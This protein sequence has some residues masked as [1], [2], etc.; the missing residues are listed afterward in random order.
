[1]SMNFVDRD[2]VGDHRPLLCGSMTGI[3]MEFTAY[4]DRDME[5]GTR[6]IRLRIERS[7]IESYKGSFT[8]S[9]SL[10]VRFV[11]SPP[12][13]QSDALLRVDMAPSFVYYDP[14]VVTRVVEFFK[15][16]EEL[17]LN[18]LADLSVA[19]AEQLS[20]ARQLAQEYAVAAWS[21]KPKLDMRLILNAPK[22]S[23]PSKAGD[24]HLALDF[25]TFI[26]ETDREG[27]AELPPR[28]MGLYECIRISGSQVSARFMGSTV[29]WESSSSQDSLLEECSLNMPLHIARYADAELPA[30]RAAPI[31]PRIRL[32]L[33][34]KKLNH[35][36]RVLQNCL[37]SFTAQGSNATAAAISGQAWLAAAEWE[38]DASYS[39]GAPCSHRPRGLDTDWSCILQR[40]TPSS[41]PQTESFD[42]GRC[43]PAQPSPGSARSPVS[44]T[45]S[46]GPCGMPKGYL[47]FTKARARW[48][49][50]T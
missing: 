26:I 4:P 42:N 43:R 11:K 25:G 48:I 37:E 49:H 13:G 19:A 36:G 15:P 33:S 20:R 18:D 30:M 29:D 7:A 45:T 23:I 9:K 5:T 10:A 46:P 12:D 24:V 27:L 28:E 40:Y 1:M 31:V 14:E 39:S 32:T 47:S 17:V 41:R 44:G 38:R 8:E 16:P 6:D 2:G 34:P 22:I 50:G 3:D 35:L 21:G